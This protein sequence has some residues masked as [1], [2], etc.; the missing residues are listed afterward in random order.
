MQNP[1]LPII[2]AWIESFE[3]PAVSSIFGR[4]DL[5]VMIM[6]YCP[7][8]SDPSRLPGRIYGIPVK[9]YH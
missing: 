8:N 6:V 7:A 9:S 1:V 4:W 5:L 3:D 2:D